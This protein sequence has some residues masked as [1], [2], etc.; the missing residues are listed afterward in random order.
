M[1]DSMRKFWRES[2]AVL[3]RWMIHVL[4][5][6][7]TY[8]LAGLEQ[9]LYDVLP[10]LDEIVVRLPASNHVL[11][12]QVSGGLGKTIFLG[13]LLGYEAPTTR[14]WRDL[15]KHADIILDVGAHIGLFAILA[16]DANPACQVYAFEPLPV[17][18]SLLCA[19]IQAS[20]MQTRIT[21]SALAISDHTGPARLLVKGSSGSTLADDFW[22]DSAE[23]SQIEVQATTLDSWL[24]SRKLVL[25]PRSIVKL[26]VETHEPSV[27]REAQMALAQGPALFC[28]VLATF[29]EAELTDL[30]P[31]SRWRCFWIGPDGPT[32]RRRIVGDPAWQ[33]MN[34]LFLTKHS[35]YLPL[36][37]EQAM[38]H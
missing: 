36:I 27:L 32:E 7:R 22:A 35:P 18:Y 16:A 25:T 28:E 2:R 8:L 12:L 38:G 37:G 20:G 34:Y 15:C 13:G 6:Q 23:L 4:R 1:I 29:V 3:I 17:N 14:L 26:D 11:K 19:N 30:L 9:W 10:Y 24:Q 21:P 31:A 33:H 5:Q